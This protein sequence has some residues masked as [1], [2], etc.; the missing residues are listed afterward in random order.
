MR[1]TW[2]T[3]LPDVAGSFLAKE[4]SLASFAHDLR[5]IFIHKNIPPLKILNEALSAGYSPREA[6][7]EPFT[8]DRPEYDELVKDLLSKPTERYKQVAPPEEIKTFEQWANWLESIG[9]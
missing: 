4:A 7:W 9:Y 5:D 8:I 3:L 2:Y 1:T 6:E